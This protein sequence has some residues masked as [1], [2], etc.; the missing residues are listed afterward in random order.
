MNDW[1]RVQLSPLN[2]LV[3]KLAGSQMML[4]RYWLMIRSGSETT[5]SLVMPSVLA[6][7]PHQN[8]I[9]IVIESNGSC[10]SEI[11]THFFLNIKE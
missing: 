4:D 3:N 10:L 11:P 7:L 2:G 6:Y 8:V 5:A 1:Y 9:D